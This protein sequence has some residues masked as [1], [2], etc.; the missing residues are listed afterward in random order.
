MIDD[1]ADDYKKIINYLNG[2]LDT[3]E[4]AEIKKINTKLPI[5]LLS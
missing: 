3:K 5:K 4:I 1:F 2:K